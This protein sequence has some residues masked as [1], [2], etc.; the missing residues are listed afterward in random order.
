MKDF[1][2]VDEKEVIKKLGL[3][4]EEDKKT[5]ETVSKDEKK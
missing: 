1:E 4:K 2:N 3:M 5:E